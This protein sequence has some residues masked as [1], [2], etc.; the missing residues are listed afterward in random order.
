M[1]VSLD[2]L[3]DE[4]VLFGG[5]LKNSMIGTGLTTVAA[6]RFVLVKK[7]EPW[8][9]GF[10]RGC[11]VQHS[12]LKEFKVFHNIREQ[13][14]AQIQKSIVAV[15]TALVAEVED[16]LADDL[17]LD[18]VG[19]A[20]TT[21][22]ANRFEQNT[23]INTKNLKFIPNVKAV[24]V[25][26]ADAAVGWVASFVAE[27]SA[28]VRMELNEENL[29]NLLKA[30][31]AEAADLAAVAGAKV[32]RPKG[33]SSPKKRPGFRSPWGNM[34]QRRLHFKDRGPVVLTKGVKTP[35]HLRTPRRYSVITKKRL[36]SQSKGERVVDGHDTD[37]GRN[38]KA[39]AARD[40]EPREQVF[41]SD[42]S[43]SDW[44]GE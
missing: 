1:P 25:A 24:P 2:L 41:G 29:E 23:A 3:P 34:N 15:R 28:S 7:G 31:E 14:R 18:A 17:G 40:K 30:V 13:V 10:T 5:R 16:D 36:N 6:Q 9:C 8:L 33:K 43:M 42:D 26:V 21:L 19:I 35:N 11:G 4:F 22:K 20:A 39:S 32:A 44:G 12:P 37:A 38:K 27:N